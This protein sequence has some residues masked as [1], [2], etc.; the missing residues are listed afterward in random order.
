MDVVDNFSKIQQE[1]LNLFIKKNHDYGESY[2][3][4]GLI[5]VLVRLGDK[6]KR[7]QNITNKGIN[8]V[9]DESLRD[10]LIDLQNYST[11][12]IM[13]Y[14]DNNDKNNNDISNNDISNNDKNNN[15]KNDNNDNDKNDIGLII[16]EAGVGN[17]YR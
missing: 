4:Y 13:L 10:T 9:N 7:L 2:K 3:D 12:A 16:S 6:I 1:G 8:L 17:I 15:D 11:M 14:D 5:G